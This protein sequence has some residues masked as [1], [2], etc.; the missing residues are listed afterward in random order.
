MIMLPGDCF[1]HENFS[2]IINDLVLLDTL[3]VRLVIV[4]GARTQIEQQLALSGQTSEFEDRIRV[5]TREQ[6]E[7]VLKAVG[8]ARFHLEACFSAGLPGSPL[9]GAK[10][11]VQGGNF[12]SAKPKGV[13][14]GVDFQ[15]TGKVRNIDRQALHDALDKNYIVLASP[16]GYSLTGEVFNL[17]FADVA[18][19]ISKALNADKLIAYNDDGPIVNNEGEQ[20]RELTL[21]QCER[22]LLEDP[23]LN[24]SNTYFSLRACH[25][26]CENGVSRAHVISA[27]EDGALIKELFTQDGSGTMVHRDSYETVR[28]ANIED[29]GGVLSLIAPLEEQ[30]I[31]VKRSR[32]LLE[33][34][35]DC[36]VVM[37]KDNLII[38]CAAL[39]PLGDGVSGELACLAINDTYMRGGRA[40]TLLKHIEKKAQLLKLEQLYVLTTQTAHWFIE[41]G[42][43]ETHIDMLPVERKS[44]YNFQRKSKVLIK[45]LS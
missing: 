24:Q 8:A 4:H 20:F 16:L 17:S 15:L 28:R 10:I 33:N 9:H 5:T 19:E 30:G 29:V 36:F 45:S 41:Q 44:L 18:I 35:I 7:D 31:L 38:G 42:F 26:A 1:T 6:I 22:F 23:Q 21:L 3:G 43:A 2:N 11:R 34:E 12:V 13:I 14:N 25:K 37:V 40:A 32:E 27:Q 39:Y